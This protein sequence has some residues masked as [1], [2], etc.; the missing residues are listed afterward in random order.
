M[1]SHVKAIVLPAI[2]T[3]CVLAMTG[4]ASAWG[5][6]QSHEPA[7]HCRWLS[8]RL[9]EAQSITPGM[10]E[11][12]LLKVFFPDGGLQR[13]QPQVFVLRSCAMIKVDVKFDWP[14]GSAPGTLPSPAELKI[15]AIS[16]PYLEYMHAD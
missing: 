2:G 5:R 16:R 11:A 15:K 14:E 3:V 7:D 12:D 6:L 10:T 4:E 8:E 13:F 9:R 1:K